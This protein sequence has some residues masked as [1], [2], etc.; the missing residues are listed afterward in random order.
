MGKKFLLAATAASVLALAAPAS[1]D[2]I[3]FDPD[4]A[5]PAE[6]VEIIGFDWEPGNGIAVTANATSP[7]DTQ[8]QFY[9]Q[10]S[11]GAAEAA[12]L[13]PTADVTN[14]EFGVYYTLVIGFGEVLDTVT[15][16]PTDGVG[17]TA[18]GFEFDPTAEY[19]FFQI[20]AN[21]TFANDL[22]GACYVC[23]ELILSGHV[24]GD[25]FVSSFTI[26][27]E[28][29]IQ[30]LDQAAG[31]DD[32]PGV[33][34][35]VGSGSTLL[36]VA[37]D[38][39]STAYFSGLDGATITF[40]TN[41]ATQ[42]IPYD[43]VNPSACFFATAVGSVGPEDYLTPECTSAADGGAGDDFFDTVGLNAFVGVGSIENCTA[44]GGG[45]ING[46]EGNTLL[47]VDGNSSFV[48]EQVNVVPEPATLTLLGLG[49]LGG[50]A[51]RRRQQRKN[52]N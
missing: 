8:F 11:L 2:N 46:C 32:Y 34:S 37:V 42:T 24:I 44:L 50:A 28:S 25:D 23:G 35:F 19:N 27:E 41:D 18:L 36:T 3:L 1:A 30:D 33:D 29:G 6:A 16:D 15:G 40:A 14:G 9:Y 39:Y 45:L 49:L 26:T 22:E 20:Y 38:S 31:N 4:G 13:D 12:A 51:A 47:E 48:T 52:Q 5:G 21:D 7:E 10:S 17:E 43:A